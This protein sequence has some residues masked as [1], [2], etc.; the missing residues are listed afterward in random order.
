M[1][2]L[3]FKISILALHLKLHARLPMRKSE[4]KV[5]GN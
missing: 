3:L 4:N 2:L 1:K 5:L